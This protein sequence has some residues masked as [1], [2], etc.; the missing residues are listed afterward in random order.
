MSRFGWAY[1]N[2]VITGSGGTTNPGG[3]DKQIQFNSGSTFSGSTNLTFNYTT[4]NVSL[5][6]AL[7]MSGTSYISD[8]DYIDFDVSA[9]APSHKNGRVYW[10]NT[11]GCLN[12]YNAET[13]IT[14]QVGQENWTR[15]FNDT[16]ATITNGTVV[17][18]NGTH[19]DVPTVEKAASLAVSGAVNVLNQILGLAT[20]DIEINTYGYITTQGLV[21]G[22]NTN[23]FSDG[24]TLFVSSSAG[25]ITNVP[26]SAPYE[27]IPIGVCVK[28]SPGG[29][30]IIYVAVQ[31]PLDFSD[32]STAYVSGNYHYGDLWNYINWWNHFCFCRIT[33]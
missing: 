23:A 33:D 3:S 27:I 13:D 16:G 29:S 8:V 10:N 30:G 11:D 17:R 14:L 21:K 12:V 22:L 4:N 7:L 20:H 26:P 31:E 25:L 6:G 32:L 1:V 9:S 28:A 5:T 24:E 19:G 15:I 2:D 18:L